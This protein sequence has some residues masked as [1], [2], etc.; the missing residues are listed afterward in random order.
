MATVLLTHAEEARAL[1]YG[2]EALARLREL[3]EVRLNETGRALSTAEVIRLAGGCQTIVSDRMTEGPAAVFG[4]L[5]E[6]VAF[7][8]C[9]VDIRNVDVGAASAAGVLVTRASAGFMYWRKPRNQKWRASARAVARNRCSTRGIVSSWF[10]GKLT[11]QQ[12]NL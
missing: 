1:Y 2:D 3:G 11:P 4:Q 8:R 5:P 12:A 7:V 10:A 6:L 9:A